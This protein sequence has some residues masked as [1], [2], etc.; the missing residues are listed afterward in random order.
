MNIKIRFPEDN[1][2][3]RDVRISFPD[4]NISLRHVRISSPDARFRFPDIVE[5]NIVF[6]KGLGGIPR[7]KV[8]A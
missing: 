7:K 8:A 4:I 6:P 2:S 1:I 3:F 5:R